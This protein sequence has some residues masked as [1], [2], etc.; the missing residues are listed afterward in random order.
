M[1]TTQTYSNHVRWF[2]L[3]HFVVVPL[4]LINLIYQTIR[5]LQEPTID[6]GF[7][8][9]LSFAVI[10]VNLAARLQSLKAQDR[11]IRLE[12][13]LRYMEVL[14]P[15]LAARASAL[16]VG[17]LI[18]LRFAPDEELPGLVTKVLDGSLSSAKEIKS[19]I[20]NWRGDHLRV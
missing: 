20:Q 16:P 5:L 13:G 14:S 19:A 1:K 4:L 12:E 2:P 10:L 17:K 9:L 8:V 3:F 6:R 18:S 11:V 7:L 15:D